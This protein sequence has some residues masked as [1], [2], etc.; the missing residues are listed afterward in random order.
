MEPRFDE[1]AVERV[2]AQVL[3]GIRSDATDPNRIASRTFDTLAYGEPSLRAALGRDDRLGDGAHARRPRGGACRRAGARPH[4]CGRGGRHRARGTRR[5]S[6]R[7]SGRPARDGAPDP[8]RGALPPAGRHLG[9]ALRHAAVGGA[10][11]PFRDRPRRPG[12]LRGLRRERDLRRLGLPVAPDA[13]GAGPAR[14]D[15][16]HRHLAHEHGPVGAS[17]GAGRLGQR[18]DGRDDRGRARPNGRGSPRRASPRRNSRPPRPTSPAPIRFASTATA[19]S[20]A[21]SSACRWTG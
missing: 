5:A 14:P 1:D 3:S 17:D 11:R 12:L 13:G 18:P 8:R 21:S 20:R 2:R 16:R 7:A 9:R 15:L 10:F 19:R 6:R 4:L